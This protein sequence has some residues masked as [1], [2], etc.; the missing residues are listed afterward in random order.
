MRIRIGFSLP[1]RRWDRI[2][3]PQCLPAAKPAKVITVKGSPLQPAVSV[4]SS[5]GSLAFGPKVE[6]AFKLVDRTGLVV[7]MRAD[8]AIHL[9][10]ELVVAVRM[11][12]RKYEMAFGMDC[13]GWA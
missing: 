2:V 11:S 3:Y 10:N 1:R 9:A 6:M 5:C 4:T 7:E 12:E 13:R 8:E